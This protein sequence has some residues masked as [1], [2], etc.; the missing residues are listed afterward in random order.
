[1]LVTLPNFDLGSNSIREVISKYKKIK[2][3]KVITTL[4][5]DFASALKHCD[6]ILGNSSAGIIETG[7]FKKPTIN[8]G[9]RQNGRVFGKNVINV[10]YNEKKILMAIKYAL[11]SKLQKSLKLMKN[12]YGDGNSFKKIKSGLNFYV[13]INKNILINK[14][15]IDLKK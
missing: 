6:L 2:N 10:I 3:I 4:G 1:M 15:F 14:K 5:S 8:L 11:S 7:F 12:P 9:N 13:G